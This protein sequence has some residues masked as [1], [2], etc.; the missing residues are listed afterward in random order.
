MRTGRIEY[1][2]D[3][4]SPWSRRV[5]TKERPPEQGGLSL[6]GVS[7]KDPPAKFCNRCGFNVTHWP[8]INVCPNCDA[9]P[10]YVRIV[11]SLIEQAVTTDEDAQ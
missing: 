5:T 1:S 10:L 6:S 9:C 7:S 4:K 2:P 11:P 3:Y 8:G